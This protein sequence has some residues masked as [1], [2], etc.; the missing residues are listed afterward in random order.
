MSR[1]IALDQYD[2][3]IL[4]ILQKDATIS[5]KELAKQIGLSPP[6]TLVRVNHLKEKKYLQEATYNINWSKL[7]FDS[8][9]HIY[10]VIK[11]ENRDEFLKLIDSFPRVLASYE[12]RKSD[13]F[14]V[15]YCHYR[16]IL[17]GVFKNQHEWHKFWQENILETGL[18]E[19]FH[20]IRVHEV[21]KS[22]HPVCLF[23]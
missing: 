10:C 12:F 3:G 18:I 20:A 23:G 17:F 4:E 11:R 16:F 6:A 8:H 21:R 13:E 14:S 9:I 1:K 19:E 7:G 2:Y 22:K 15:D 5:N